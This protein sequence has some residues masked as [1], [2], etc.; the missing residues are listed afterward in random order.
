MPKR[1]PQPAT[2]GTLPFRPPRP[3]LDPR[4]EAARRVRPL[5]GL[6]GVDLAKLPARV[7]RKAKDH[8]ELYAWSGARF[9]APPRSLE[10][11]QRALTRVRETLTALVQGT[12]RTLALKAIT[13]RVEPQ[14]RYDFVVE[15]QTERV[16]RS[17]KKTV[18][19]GRAD[20]ATALALAVI[21]DVIV[22]GVERLKACPYRA[23][24][25]EPTCGRIFLA[26]KR[27]TWC[28]PEHRIQSAYLAW[29][30]RGRPRHA[31][32]KESKGE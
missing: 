28:S 24:P 1:P 25:A 16:R 18:G 13:V 26:Q 2:G 11:W 31:G 9:T 22:V 3:V 5:I 15:R 10:E 8:L 7:W 6:L 20:F 23:A 17:W 12:P 21:D 14:T 32:F 27:Q 19:L 30:R 4:K 29:T